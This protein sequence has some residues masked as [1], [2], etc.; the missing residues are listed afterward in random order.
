MDTPIK[1][2]LVGRWSFFVFPLTPSCKNTSDLSNKICKA[3]FVID[4]IKIFT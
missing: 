2:C 1:H 4:K 3:N